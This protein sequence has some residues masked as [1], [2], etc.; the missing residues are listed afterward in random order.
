M[1]FIFIILS[2]L[3]FTFSEAFPVS[4]PVVVLKGENPVDF[5]IAGLTL[6]ASGLPTDFVPTEFVW[7][8][9]NIVDAPTPISDYFSIGWTNPDYNDVLA[10]FTEPVRVTGSFAN[11]G[12]GNTKPSAHG[13]APIL[14]ASTNI[15]V[16]VTTADSVSTTNLQDIYIIGYYLY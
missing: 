12:F 11:Y 13:T 15:Y 8:G 5:K 1:K 6:I 9:V 10:P 4:N 16:N 2:F 7:Y 3:V 14:P